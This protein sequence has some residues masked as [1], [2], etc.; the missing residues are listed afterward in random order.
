MG[1]RPGTSPTGA[2]ILEQETDQ[3]GHPSIHYDQCSV[4]GTVDICGNS[5]EGCLASLG[6]RT[7]QVCLQGINSEARFMALQL[8]HRAE[9]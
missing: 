2:C 9:G 7:N 8:L 1:D 5:Q 6:G 4:R 3:G